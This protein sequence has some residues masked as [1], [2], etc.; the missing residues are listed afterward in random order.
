[1]RRVFAQIAQVA[2]VDVPVLITGESGTGKELVARAIHRG[3][4][5]RAAPLL[6][7]NCGTLSPEL[8]ASE[9]FGHEKGAFTGATVRSDGKLQAADGGSLFLD[10]VTTMDDRAQ[11]SL[12]RVLETGSFQRVGGSATQ[13]ADVRVLSATNDDVHEAIAAG[14]FREDL[15]YRIGAFLIALP[16][17][18][19]RPG[20][21]EML[22]HHF[23]E[24]QCRELYPGR[25]IPDLSAEALK[26]LVGHTWPGNVR[27]LQN[28]MMRSLVMSDNGLLKPE[29]VLIDGNQT[30]DA[31]QS[32]DDEISVRIGT[33]LRDVERICLTRT[34]ESVGG[35]KTRA[36]RLL[37][38]SRKAIYNKLRRHR[39]L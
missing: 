12:L 30:E 23:V 11:V 34:L 39:L 5:R 14:T 35:N 4:R 27:E 33:P 15:F 6:A 29:H 20:D 32:A 21:V 36:S 26:K 1:M 10:E 24:A 22:A 13:H 8:V 37:G 18:R 19:E 7:I 38:I 2:R 25:E 9:L 28:V 31:I 3:S 17:L 16:P